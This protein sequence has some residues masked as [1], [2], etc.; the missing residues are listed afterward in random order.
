MRIKTNG[1]WL[2]AKQIGPADAEEVVF[3]TGF[4]GAASFWDLML[5]VIAEKYHVTIFDQR[6][7][8]NSGPFNHPLT[9]KQM[10]D[11]AQLILH[12]LCDKPVHLLGHSAGAGI[13]LML[14]GKLPEKIKS[15]TLLAGWT[16]AD[17]WMQ[18]VFDAR[19]TALKHSGPEAYAM[20]TTLFMTPHTDVALLDKS[21]NKA[22]LQYAKQ[23]PVYEEIKARAE[24]V[25]KFDSNEFIADV[26][27]P[28]LVMGAK[29]DA[30]TPFY[31]SQALSK[32]I[33]HS[34]LF[35]LETGGHYFPRTRVIETLEPILRFLNANK[36]KQ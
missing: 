35:E 4:I 28:T 8:G 11:D 19:L 23:M 22:E 12:D 3:I 32:S 29:D 6:G 24:A 9:M 13:S 36:N 7:T 30:M 1:S 21:L 15:I 34:Q 18:R 20:L 31:F 5:P 16:K 26:K 14:A 2:A 10:A 17:A 33:P 25:S 27:C